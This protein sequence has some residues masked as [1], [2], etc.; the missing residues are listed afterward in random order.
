M[1]TLSIFQQEIGW[2]RERQKGCRSPGRDRER[3][4]VHAHVC[5][6]RIGSSPHRSLHTVDGE[7]GREAP[8]ISSQRTVVF[9]PRLELPEEGA[10][11]ASV[12][13]RSAQGLV[14]NRCSKNICSV[15]C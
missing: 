4:R 1:I 15:N 9:V 13:I 14:H 12:T 5:V 2:D 11:A 6:L 7:P 10:T 3:V 8:V